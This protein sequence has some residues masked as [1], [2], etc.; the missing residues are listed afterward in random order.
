MIMSTYLDSAP[1]G[2]QGIVLALDD[3]HS[4]TKELR[5]L[6]LHEGVLVEVLSGV[7]PVILKCQHGK[8]AV[9]RESLAAV[10]VGLQP[11]RKKLHPL[12]FLK[13]LLHPLPAVPPAQK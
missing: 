3:K 1:V 4:H 6:G 9:R 11:G 12:S 7:D 2:S 5:R 10:Q 8:F 13:S